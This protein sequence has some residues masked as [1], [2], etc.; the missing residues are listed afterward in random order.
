MKLCSSPLR[1][2]VRY[3][4][5]QSSILKSGNRTRKR[6]EVVNCL[7]WSLW[8]KAITPRLLWRQR[9]ARSHRAV[10]H[11]NRPLPKPHISK[12]AR[13]VG[14]LPCSVLRLCCL[15]HL[16]VQIPLYLI[17]IY[18]GYICSMPFLVMFQVLNFSICICACVRVCVW[19]G[20]SESFLF[21]KA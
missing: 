6:P 20:H 14:A 12:R 9:E 2:S 11:G 7:E 1:S 15:T 17:F 4:C 5:Y 13:N 3:S 18:L 16:F 21:S 10:I 8:A 19:W